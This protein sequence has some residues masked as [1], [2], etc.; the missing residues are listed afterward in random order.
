MF[1]GKGWFVANFHTRVMQCKVLT[2]G[3]YFHRSNYIHLQQWTLDFDPE[4][5]TISTIMAW[6]HFPTMAL[7]Y[8][9][10]NVILEVVKMFRRP[11]K[12]DSTTEAITRARFAQVC[13]VL[14]VDKSFVAQFWVKNKL[15]H[16]AYEGLPTVCFIRGHLGHR[17]IHCRIVV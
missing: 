16:V 5:T 12:V 15:H 1:I 2:E 7:E 10:K 3:P 8:Y 6:V 4:T 13:D 11:I 9:A 17:D 14:D